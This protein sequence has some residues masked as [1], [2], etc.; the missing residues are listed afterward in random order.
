MA[1]AH[2]HDDLE[3]NLSAHDLDYVI[4]GR[5]V[6]IPAQR[7]AVFWAGRPHQLVGGG[8]GTATWITIPTPVLLSWGAGREALS[9]LLGGE[10]IVGSAA[11]TVSSESTERWGR[12][13]A[14]DD[15]AARRPAALEIE[16]LLARLLQV[17]PAVPVE[18]PAAGI[19]RA[20][21]MALFIAAHLGR[22]IGVAEVAAHVRLHPQSATRVFRE[23]TGVTISEYLLQCRI[24]EAQRL[25]MTGDEPVDAVR[26]RAGFGSSSAFHAAFQRATGSTPLAFRRARSG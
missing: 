21:E 2:R 13:L 12:E 20:G 19:D 18:R 22:A 9:R 25:L 1:D 15:A 6:S 8:G 24:S 7:P 16:A 17:A 11:M 5:V 3:I 26:V 14:A 23:A 10:V 4:G